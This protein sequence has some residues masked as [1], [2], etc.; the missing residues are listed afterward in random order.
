MVVAVQSSTTAG[1]ALQWVVEAH[2]GEVEVVSEVGPVEVVLEEGEEDTAGLRGAVLDGEEILA[3]TTV[4]PSQRTRLASRKW[5]HCSHTRTRELTSTP[6]M[7]FRCVRSFLLADNRGGRYIFWRRPGKH[8]A[9]M[10][11]LLL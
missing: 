4:I 5:T 6:T 9:E 11:V 8:L 10:L 1:P 3:P 2:S 7:T